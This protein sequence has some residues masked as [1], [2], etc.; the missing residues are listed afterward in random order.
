MVQ[1]RQWQKQHEDSHYAACLFHCEREYALLMKDH[2]IFV[3]IDDKHR[4][5][6][7]KS[8]NP[9]SSAECGRKVVV[10]SGSSLQSSDHDFAT[11]SIIPSVVLL[12]DIP[13]EISGSW[14]QGDF[15]V[16]FKKGLLNHHLLYNILQNW[17][18]SSVTKRKS[19]LFC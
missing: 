14:Y 2:A 8:D 9:V 1:Q 6:V 12:C 11:F 17:R 19:N 10:H 7:G 3:C 18:I 4:I 16:M 15:N 13:S 5:K